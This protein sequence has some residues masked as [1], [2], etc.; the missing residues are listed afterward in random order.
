MFCLMKQGEIFVFLRF[1]RDLKFQANL[2]DTFLDIIALWYALL[3]GLLR[4]II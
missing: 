1:L 4:S 2:F 3:N